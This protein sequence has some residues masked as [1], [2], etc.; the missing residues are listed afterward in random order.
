MGPVFALG[1]ILDERAHLVGRFLAHRNV[2]GFV[3]FLNDCELIA[4]EI[5]KMN[6]AEHR[7]G[8]RS[9]GPELECAAYDF[10][11]S[12]RPVACDFDT[13]D[14]IGAHR[15]YEGGEARIRSHRFDRI[16]VREHDARIGVGGK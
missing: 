3:D 10:M 2:E 7:I 13:V 12:C 1:I 14:L 6:I 15:S 16:A 8:E 4:D 9:A 5:R 11:E